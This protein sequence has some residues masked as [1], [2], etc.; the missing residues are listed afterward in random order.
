MDDAFTIQSEGFRA[1]ASHG[2]PSLALRY[3]NTHSDFATGAEKILGR[4]LPEQGQVWAFSSPP[5]AIVWWSPTQTLILGQGM[6]IAAFDG[7]SSSSDGCV[8]DLSGAFS[9]IRCEGGQIAEVFARLGGPGI[10][11]R[12]GEVKRGRLAELPA[13]ALCLHEGR[14]E[15]LVEHYY[16]QHLQQWIGAAVA[17]LPSRTRS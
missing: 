10:L 4:R 12:P 9:S 14:C 3:L 2:I 13:M 6:N 16:A 5:A 7:L 17:N 15:I 11:P 8:V 1:S